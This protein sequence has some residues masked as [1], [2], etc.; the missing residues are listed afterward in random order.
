MNALY[1]IQSGAPENPAIVFLHGSPLT[2]R[3]WTPQMEHLEI[4]FIRNRLRKFHP[5]YCC[6]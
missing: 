6:I 2:G 1:T 4:M 3:M 5:M